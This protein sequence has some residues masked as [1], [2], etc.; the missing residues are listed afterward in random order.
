MMCWSPFKLNLL[1]CKQGQWFGYLCKILDKFSIV[2]PTNPRKAQTC[3]GVVGG[4]IF[5]IAHVFEGSWW[6]PL[7]LKIC[8][9][10]W[11][12]LEKKWHL[13]N[14]MESFANWSFS[15]TF[16]MCDICSSAVLLKILCHLNMLLQSQNPSKCL[17]LI[18]ENVLEPELILKV[19]W[20]I[21]TCQRRIECCFRYQRLIQRY[22]MITGSQIQSWKILCSIQFGKYIFDFGHMPSELPGDFV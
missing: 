4:C 20:Y 13:L 3:L 16:L 9:K 6:M 7:V 10:Y 22:M 5:W 8:P 15:N 18:P 17:S 14:F 1:P 11:I 12:S 19:P 21:R 2:Y